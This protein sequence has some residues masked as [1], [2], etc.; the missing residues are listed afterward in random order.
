MCK[1][2]R[3]PK[4]ELTRAVKVAHRAE[5]GTGFLR[6]KEMAPQQPMFYLSLIRS[7]TVLT[8]VKICPL[9]RSDRNYIKAPNA[10]GCK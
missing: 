2:L 1:V 3:V 5:S 4:V 7:S 6:G 8:L 9:F 10:A